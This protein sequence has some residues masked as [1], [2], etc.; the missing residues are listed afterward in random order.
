MIKAFLHLPFILSMLGT[1]CAFLAYIV[2]P[3]IPRFLLVYLDGYISLLPKNTLLIFSRAL[4]WLSTVFGKLFLVDFGCM[5][6]RQGYCGVLPKPPSVL[7]IKYAKPRLV[8]VPLFIFM[9]IGL[10]VPLILVFHRQSFKTTDVFTHYLV[11]LFDAHS[12]WSH[13]P[14]L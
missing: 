9:L 2:F 12:W 7:V 8:I 3:G 6:Y 10:I 5:G 1:L 4:Y 14:R 13:Y 11:Y